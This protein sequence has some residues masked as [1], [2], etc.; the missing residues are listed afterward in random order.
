[1]Q[2]LT[3]PP[4][5]VAADDLT[6]WERSR[7]LV[8]LVVVIVA[9]VGA[10]LALDRVTT[11]SETVPFAA[12][13]RA[14]PFPRTVDAPLDT[15]G[16]EGGLGRA[17]T[18]QQW[19]D[20]AG[21]WTAGADGARVVTPAPA[22]P[23]YAL[24]RVNRGPGSIEVT[25]A[26]MAKG[27]GLAFRCRTP[28]D[29][30]T[31]T[32]VPE[33]G[34]WKVTKTVGGNATDLGN[35]TTVPVAPG[36]RMR[37]DT[38]A[39]GVDFLVDDVAVRRIDDEELNDAQK[40]GL[41][42]EPEP[43][44]DA[45]RFRDFHSLQRNIVGPGAPVH[46]SFSRPDQRGLGRTPTG[47]SWRIDRGEWGIRDRQAVLLSDPSL[48]PAL[49]T[50]D[51]GRDRGWVQ[52]TGSVIPNGFGT[53]FRYRDAEN[54]WRISAVPDFG[55]FNIFKVVGGIESQV[56]GGTGL[57]SFGPGSTIGVRLAA[58]SFTVFVDGFETVTIRDDALA[59]ETRAGMVI[60]SPKAAGARFAGFAAGPPDV[61]GGE[62]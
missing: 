51:T 6:D 29:C 18:G 30:W 37:V 15:P 8:A 47:E 38:D 1:M 59:A 28:L 26:T 4:A 52:L 23:S 11:Q 39:Q 31:V 35:L 44:G 62:R 21:Q 55:T 17:T 54:Y 25:A 48:Q 42:V 34:T 2:T 58:R 41:V 27:M 19:A 9:L 45:A 16:A 7:A 60:D 50:V 3:P 53:V 13:P 14:V 40:A 46:D 57:T 43:G 32:A 56:P 61:A 36:T 20:A 33:F 5:A 10:G 24:I 49:A 22:G 12:V